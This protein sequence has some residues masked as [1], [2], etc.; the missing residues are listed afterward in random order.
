MLGFIV[1]F[2]AAPTMTLG[3]LLFALAN[4]IWIFIAIQIERRFGQF[5]GEPYRDY[6]E[7]TPMLVPFT[8]RGKHTQRRIAWINSLPAWRRLGFYLAQMTSGQMT[9]FAHRNES[10]DKATYKRIDSL[11]R[12]LKQLPLL[13]VLGIL[14]PILLPIVPLLSLA[15]LFRVPGCCRKLTVAR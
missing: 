7:R 3:R 2:W 11:Y 10:M 12:N 9:R 15:Y 4:T 8:R 1:A 13:A 6:Q 14:V 5:L